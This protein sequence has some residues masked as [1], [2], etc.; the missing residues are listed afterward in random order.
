MKVEKGIRI[1]T[2]LRALGNSRAIPLTRDVMQ[3]AGFDP[4]QPVTIEVSDGELHVT[5]ADSVYARGM[6]IGKRLESRYAQTFKR[7]AK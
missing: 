2:K 7:L 1:N 5:K 4:D 6:E 3:A